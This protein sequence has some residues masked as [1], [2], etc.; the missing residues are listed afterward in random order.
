MGETFILD[1]GREEKD[2]TLTS[3]AGSSHLYHVDSFN[4]RRLKKVHNR[5]MED[6]NVRAGSQQLTLFHRCEVNI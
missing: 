2:L 4:S 3:A 5:V 6:T 1:Q